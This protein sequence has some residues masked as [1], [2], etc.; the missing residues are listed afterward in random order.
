MTIRFCLRHSQAGMVDVLD[1]HCAKSGCDRQPMYGNP[2]EKTG[3]PTWCPTHRPND[4]CDVKTSRCQE[5]NCQ[6]HPRFVF[7]SGR[8]FVMVMV[9]YWCWWRRRWLRHGF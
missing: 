5:P 4:S 3:K 1:R 2:G 7:F 8:L 6:K 9:L